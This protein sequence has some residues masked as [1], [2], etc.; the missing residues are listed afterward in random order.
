MCGHCRWVDQGSE[1]SFHFQTPFQDA[2]LQRALAGATRR[3]RARAALWQSLQLLLCVAIWAAFLAL[4]LLKQQFL[5][6]STGYFALCA[7]HVPQNTA[8]LHTPIA[9]YTYLLRHGR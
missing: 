9:V 2:S 1:G 4:Q 7:P 3:A 5:T 8:R 6:C